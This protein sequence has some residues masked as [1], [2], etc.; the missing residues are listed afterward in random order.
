MQKSSGEL[1][2]WAALVALLLLIP[3]TLHAH[4]G[5]VLT[6]SGTAIPDGVLQ[7]GEWD[8]AATYAFAANR[9][10]S[11]GGGTTP[12]TLF[13][14]N[15]GFNLYLGVR[16]NRSMLGIS[17]VAFQFD[18]D[19]DGITY[20]NGDDVLL[21]NPDLGFY[22]EVRTNGP[23]CDPGHP[24]GHCGLLDT[25]AGGTNDGSG[26]TNNNGVYSF[27]EFAHPL[28]SADNAHD[29]S[30]HSGNTAGFFMEVVLC[31][32]LE[33]VETSVDDGDI[34]MTAPPPPLSVSLALTATVR[35]PGFSTGQT[36]QV[37]VGIDDPGIDSIVDLFFGVLLPDGHTVITFTDLSFHFALG[38]IADLTSLEPIAANL[39]LTAPLSAS[40]SP[41]FNY[42]W[43]GSEPAGIYNWFFLAAVHDSL[44]D[45]SADPGDVVAYDV[46]DC[47]FTP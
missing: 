10:A 40:A 45:N 19:H 41:F 9:P 2:S 39:D 26:N 23:P 37:G 28:D 21:I 43:G 16:V 46:E 47:S 6:G 3:A 7:T 5:P 38:D 13:V 44:A 31:D 4:G 29:F 20:E 11:E 17:S 14:M 24:P 36:L 25:T 33:C 15:D 30:L 8:S 1:P 27:Y 32:D 18:N 35:G 12:G 34:G 42:T 22:D